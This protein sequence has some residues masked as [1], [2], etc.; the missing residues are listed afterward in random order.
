M[1]RKN[2][3][4]I[5]WAILTASFCFTLALIPLYHYLI[6]LLGQAKVD[7]FFDRTAD[8]LIGVIFLFLLAHLVKGDK[9]SPSSAYLWLVGIIV[10]GV[11]VSMGFKITHERL[12]FLTYCLLSL[13]AYRVFR[14]YTGT[15]WVYLVSFLFVMVFSIADELFQLS[16]LGG[17]NFEWRDLAIDWLSAAAGIAL[18][19]FVIRPKFEG[20]S[21][22]IQREIRH[23]HESESY[24]KKR[25]KS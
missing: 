15:R 5:D 1:I 19:A 8:V 9:K 16:G 18:V 4:I 17:R 21:F 23:L 10:A 25:G 14:H 2:K 24:L 12:H 11:V 7:I 22:G 3:I 6:V 13:L 20:S